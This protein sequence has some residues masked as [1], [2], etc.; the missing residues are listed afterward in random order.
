MKFTFKNNLKLAG[1]ISLLCAVVFTCIFVSKRNEAIRNKD[2][3]CGVVESVSKKEDDYSFSIQND[4]NIYV[5]QGN[6]QSGL[7]PK[8]IYIRIARK[9]RTNNSI[10]SIGDTVSFYTPTNKIEIK[11]HLGNALLCLGITVNEVEII[12]PSDS[13]LISEFA[14]SSIYRILFFIGIL[15]GALAF[16]FILRMIEKGYLY[17][18]EATD[19]WVE[20]DDP[21]RAEIL[22]KKAIKLIPNNLEPILMYAELLL[23]LNRD[24]EA[25]ALYKRAYK[26]DK[27]VAEIAAN[28]YESVD[29]NNEYAKYW[30]A[31]VKKK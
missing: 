26:K 13:F 22:Y 18:Y 10:I 28:H 24:D 16:L 8:L 20:K 27:S 4:K 6:V 12:S 3:H 7:L 17:M 11:T 9:Y 29:G 30:R 25:N 23:S 19:L 14:Q 5:L 2:L 31:K 15:W 1:A 21:V